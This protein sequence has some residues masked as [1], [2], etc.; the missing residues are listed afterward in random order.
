MLSDLRYLATKRRYF[1]DVAKAARTSPPRT[2]PGCG[3]FGPF[4][5]AGHPPRYSARCPSCRSLERHRLFALMLQRLAPIAVG[6]QVLHFAPEPIIRDL[7]PEGVDYRSADIQPGRADLV[8]NLEAIALPDASVDV[9]LANHV[10]EHVDDTKALPELR[11][12]LRPGGRLI[13]T[14]PIAEGWET[15]YENPAITDPAER[16][17]HFGQDDHVRYYG[18]DLRDRVA[19]G[20]LALAEFV[21]SGEESVRHG[22]LRGSRVFIA[23]RPS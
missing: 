6:D 9:I 12:I 3:F 22:L 5:P 8:L 16:V 20:G 15:T 18:R 4:D 10:L 1:L 17:V 13:M 2:C 11:R 14:V 19:A 7:L 21:A 23:T